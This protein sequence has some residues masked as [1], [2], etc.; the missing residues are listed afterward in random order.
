MHAALDIDRKEAT[1]TTAAHPGNAVQPH[2]AE[3][4]SAN[5]D[6][7]AEPHHPVAHVFNAQ[8]LKDQ[9]K[10]ELAN[11]EKAYDVKKFYKEDGLISLIA[12][13]PVFD[14]LTMAVIVFYALWMAIDTDYNTGTMLA[15]THPVFI[16]AEQLFCAYFTFELVVR[17]LAFK[18][19]RNCFRDAWFVFDF[20]L[21]TMM[22]A[23]TWVLAPILFFLSSGGGQNP[24]QDASILRLARLLRLTR[25]LRMARLIRMFPE[26]LIMVKAIAAAARSVGFTLLLQII[27]LY[28]FAIAMTQTLKE[29][30]IGDEYFKTVGMS[31]HSLTM[32]GTFLDAVSDIMGALLQESVIGFVIMYI[33]VIISA[34]TIM[35]MLIGVLCEVITAVSD[36]E[37]EALRVAWMTETLKTALDGADEN[38]DGFI[39]VDE[40]YRMLSDERVQDVLDTVEIDPVGLIDFVDVIFDGGEPTDDKPGA[41][42]QVPFE[43]FKDRLL[44][45]RGSNNCTVKDMI[46]LRKWLASQI[47]A[48]NI[49][50]TKMIKQD[51]DEDDGDP[52]LS[53]KTLHDAKPPAPSKEPPA[54]AALFAANLDDASDVPDATLSP[55]RNGSKPGKPF[56]TMHS[57]V[58]GQVADVDN[59]N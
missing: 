26:L 6:H 1:E 42:P 55:T 43:V 7:H 29:T 19:K 46:G 22:V 58:P 47:R 59:E 53:E 33:F 31:I 4:S 21:V 54:P 30:S 36:A 44:E 15:D 57:V 28:V 2:N 45:L 27:C 56:T 35:N 49:R 24:L 41:K 8:A 48:Q 32:H 10:D 25:L 38:S 3:A 23:E 50:I 18:V 16:T 51:K 39:D 12:K 52:R 13:H 5:G 9:L 11:P 20:I 17:F 34:I 37:T 40:F 14:N